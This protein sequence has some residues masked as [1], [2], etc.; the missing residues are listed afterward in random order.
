MPLKR[1]KSLGS[2][3][4]RAMLLPDD[5]T[6]RLETQKSERTTTLEFQ[7]LLDAAAL[8]ALRTAIAPA[9][10]S[11]APAR[12]VLRAGTQV[13]RACLEGLRALGADLVAESPYLARWIGEG[14]LG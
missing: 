6:H 5:M 1:M 13:D 2:R 12:I 3:S 10:A 4:A 7:G 11:G 8:A 9:L 14:N